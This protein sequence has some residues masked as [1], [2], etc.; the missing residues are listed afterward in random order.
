MT[1]F[2]ELQSVCRSRCGPRIAGSGFLTSC[3]SSP[4]RQSPCAGAEK[5]GIATARIDIIEALQAASI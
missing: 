5:H 1:R 4:S 2:P 3:D